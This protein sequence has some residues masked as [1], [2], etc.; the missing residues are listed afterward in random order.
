MYARERSFF[1][2]PLGRLVQCL[3]LAVVSVALG[4]ALVLVAQMAAD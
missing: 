2:T 4:S 3:L 1:Q